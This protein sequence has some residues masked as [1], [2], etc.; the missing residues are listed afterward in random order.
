MDRRSMEQFWKYYLENVDKQVSNTENIMSLAEKPQQYIPILVDVDLKHT[1][2]DISPVS[3]AIDD[4]EVD[5]DGPVRK[6]VRG[7][8]QLGLRRVTVLAVPVA[9]RPLRKPRRP[10]HPR[11]EVLQQLERGRAV[12]DCGGGGGRDDV[13]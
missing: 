12:C 3:S 8:Q 10:T 4:D 1:V 9:K 5:R 7:R 13:V 6:A 11:D 2:G